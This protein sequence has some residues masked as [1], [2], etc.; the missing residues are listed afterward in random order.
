MAHITLA[1]H[2]VAYRTANMPEGRAKAFARCV[3]AN[4]RFSEAEAVR[5]DRTKSPSWYVRFRPSSESRLDTMFHTLQDQRAQRA[6]TQQ[7]I[8]WQDP[9]RAD[10]W[11]C[12]SVSSQQ[13]YE[14]TIG[15]CSCEDYNFVCMNSGMQCKHMIAWS[16]QRGA[17]TLLT[18]AELAAKE[19]EG[20]ASDKRRLSRE[21]LAARMDADFGPA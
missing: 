1:D 13:T 19:R 15:S 20:A 6:A 7:F 8:F 18:R 9:D 17:G 11:W 16:N 12:Y 4:P 5:N 2:T 14:V 10:L 3:A 21:E